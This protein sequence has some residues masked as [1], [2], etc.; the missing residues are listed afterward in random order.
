MNNSHFDI[1]QCTF[2]VYKPEAA[3]SLGTS[4]FPPRLAR[5]HPPLLLVLSIEVR[6]PHTFKTLR[7]IGQS[8]QRDRAR[9]AVRGPTKMCVGPSACPPIHVP[10]I[11][12][13]ALPLALPASLWPCRPLVMRGGT[14]VRP[15]CRSRGS[16]PPSRISEQ[17]QPL[18]RV[19]SARER[20]SGRLSE[21]GWLSA[22]VAA[23]TTAP[24]VVALRMTQL[25][26]CLGRL[27]CASRTT[28]RPEQERQRH[29]QPCQ[30]RNGRGWGR[31]A[32]IGG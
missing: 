7:G 13:T 16:R 26:E 1:D 17:D 25:F 28:M 20:C 29:Y 10:P 27:A 23:R 19:A 6:P 3:P 9:G 4:G 8:A 18:A 14:L 2:G 5:Y 12:R 21:E 22:S 32:E 15:S 31:Q 24:S 11:W 30:P